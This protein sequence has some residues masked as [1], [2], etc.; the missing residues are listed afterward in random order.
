MAF[1]VWPEKVGIVVPFSKVETA[2][3]GAD[4][5][6][7]EGQFGSSCVD[8]PALLAARAGLS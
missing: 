5:V 6:E 4:L 1:R 3:G 2:R 7:G 8:V